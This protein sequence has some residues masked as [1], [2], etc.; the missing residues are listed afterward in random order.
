MAVHLKDNRKL[1]I[2][3]MFLENVSLGSVIN[4]K[5]LALLRNNR[6]KTLELFIYLF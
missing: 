3:Q 1:K 2:I 4:K 6:N 5:M